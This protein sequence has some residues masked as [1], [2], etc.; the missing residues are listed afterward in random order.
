MVRHNRSAAFDEAFRRD[1]GPIAH[2]S[3]LA[4]DPNDPATV[5]HRARTLQAAWRS[6]IDDRIRFL[7][8]RC[9]DKNVLD[10]GCVA[11][12]EAR[13]EGDEWLHGRIA[14]VAK[15]CLGVDILESGV[16][17][18]NA[19]GYDA[20]VHDLST[21]LGPLGDRGPF[22]V[23][24]AGELIEHVP[25]LDMV[26][27]AAAEGLADG[28]Q[29]ILTTPNPYAPQRV[30]AGQLGIVWENVDHT[31]YL[32]PSGVAELAERRGLVLSEAAT[33]DDSLRPAAS[34]LQ[35]LKRSIRGSHWRNVG[36]ATGDGKGQTSVDAGAL[37]RATRRLTRPQPRFVGETFVYVVS[38]QGGARPAAA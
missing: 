38:H 15:R 21:G 11:H 8:D 1:P 34:P 18:V 12:D 36:Y 10:I 19:A 14:R 24:V 5:A 9:R 29:L 31:S 35:R 23:I 3:E 16:E 4:A 26:F 30:R 17:A 28:G 27:R 2:W 20:V 7:E 25:D 37:V 33:V 32:F 6:S 22:D 13:L